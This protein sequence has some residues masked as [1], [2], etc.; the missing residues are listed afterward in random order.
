MRR[1]PVNAALP[2]PSAVATRVNLRGG[3][4]LRYIRSRLI[5]AAQRRRRPALGGQVERLRQEGVRRDA[6]SGSRTARQGVSPGTVHSYESAATYD[7][8]LSLIHISEPT[9]L[10]MISYA[11]FCL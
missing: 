9:R 7:P 4:P 8:V 6:T 10:G 2:P 3:A 11:V 5:E 1:L